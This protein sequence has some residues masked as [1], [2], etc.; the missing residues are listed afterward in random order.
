MDNLSDTLKKL[1]ITAVDRTE[2]SLEGCLDCLLQALTQNNMETSEKI[3]GSGILQLFSSLLIP[4][5][6]CTAKV[7]NIIAEVAKN[8][9]MRIPCVDAGLISPL[10]Q[11]LNSKDQEVLLQTGRALGNIC[12]DSHEGRS[13]VDQAGGAQIVI[14]HLRS[15]C[16][17]TDPANEKLLTVFCGMLMNYSNENDSLQAQ[18]INMGVIP[19]LVTLLGIHYQNAALTEMCLIAFG[20]LAELESSKEQFASTNIAEEMVKLFKKQIEHDKREMI[21]EVLAPLAENDA[22][23][24]QLVEAGLV[25]CLLEIV[26]QKVDSDKEDDVAELKTASDL[27]V[28]L[29]LGGLEIISLEK[30]RLHCLYESMQKLFEGGK[31]N[32]FQRVLSWIPSN[33]HQLQLAGALA[34]ANFARND[35]NCI[36][37]VDNGIVEKLMDLL[38]R[39]VEDGNVTVQHAALSALRNLAIPVVN[40][41]KMLS[42]GV[43]EAVLKFLKS[44]MP[45]VQ[46]KLL[47][48]LRMLIDAQA[49]A[50][51]Q[52]GKNIKLVERLVEWCEAK[53]HAGVMGESNRLL[54]A[55]I[56]HSKSK[57]VIKTIVQSGGI[58][59]LVTMATSEHVIMQN[60][61]LVALALIAAL[62]LDTA[63]KDLESAKLVQILHKLLAD[64]RSAPEIKYNSMVLICA[65]MG[66]ESLHKEVQDLAFLDVVSKLRSHEN[67]SVAQQASLTE[68]RLTV[69]S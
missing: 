46:F 25:E 34:I 17:I 57:D 41:A 30:R 35:G 39:H 29:L 51:E 2:D 67:K 56:R 52:L 6:S 64:E 38:D 50:A 49:E 26:Q 20:N 37:M 32:V 31:G 4:Q 69:E 59:H 9:F 68:Q 65:L 3:Q 13:A 15:L 63:E 53:D 33:N 55:L 27:M 7:A 16:S 54:S 45:P 14:D 19:T 23:K 8:E 61:A 18:L 5:S 10:V 43:T 21:F 62:E 11:L 28:L 42:A 40:K 48:T 66:S 44:E 22:I 1:K 60:E 47:G 24:L 36:H 12:Y 58:K